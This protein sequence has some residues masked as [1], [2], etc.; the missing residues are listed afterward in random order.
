[1]AITVEQL[2][3]QQLGE[4]AFRIAVL[5]AEND[6]LKEQVQVLTKQIPKDNDKAESINTGQQN[7]NPPNQNIR[8]FDPDS[9]CK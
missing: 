7:T 3:K 1:M 4:S 9:L 8:K 6:K 5:T 2:L